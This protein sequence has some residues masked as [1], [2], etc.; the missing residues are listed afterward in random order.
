MAKR[1]DT[2]EQAQLIIFAEVYGDEQATKRYG[3]SLRSLQRYRGLA[4][5]EGSELAQTVAKYHAALAPTAAQAASFSDYLREQA[6]AASQ[7]FIEKANEINPQNPDALRVLN[8][9]FQVLLQYDISVEYI[10]QL[11]DAHDGKH[12]GTGPQAPV[13]PT[14]TD[15]PSWGTPAPEATA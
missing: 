9:H 10:G 13:R 4:R 2:D 1:L 7:L 12:G 8:E 11:F 3:V 5:T 14:A 15:A 6:R